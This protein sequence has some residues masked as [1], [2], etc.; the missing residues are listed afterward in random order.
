MY[1]CSHRCR[2]RFWQQLSQRISHRCGCREN[3]WCPLWSDSPSLTTTSAQKHTS[4]WIY[5]TIQDWTQ[6]K[7]PV[8][9]L[10]VLPYICRALQG[11][12]VR[13]W[14]FGLASCR[15]TQR[16]DFSDG[17]CDSRLNH[18][19]RTTRCGTQHCNTRCQHSCT[20][21]TKPKQTKTGKNSEIHTPTHIHTFF[22][23]FAELAIVTASF[24]KVSSNT[25]WQ[26]WIH[27]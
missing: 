2:A 25:Y 7:L 26:M 13:A 6:L 8:T 4:K 14:G 27:I 3:F 22:K 18:R 5:Q 21:K 11:P 1:V 17:G 20:C 23:H 24:L 12:L 15:S 19:H 10:C 9:I 16:E